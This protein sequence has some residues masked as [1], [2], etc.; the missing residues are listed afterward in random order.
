MSVFFLLIFSHTQITHTLSHTLSPLYLLQHR[1]LRVHADHAQRSQR[2][3][4]AAAAAAAAA[5][6]CGGR[7]HRVHAGSSARCGGGGRGGRVAG[8][9]WLGAVV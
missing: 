5:L 3:T 7:R 9:R 1:R 4:T 8:G 6:P 2:A